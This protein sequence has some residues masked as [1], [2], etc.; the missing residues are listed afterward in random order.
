MLVKIK[1]YQAHAASELEFNEPG[2]N[3]IIGPSDSGKSSIIRAIS[4]LVDGSPVDRRHKTRETVVEVDGCRRVRG[5]SANQFE[6]G[7]H[8]YKAMRSEAPREIKEKLNLETINFRSQHQPYFLLADSPGAV[9]RSMNELADLG[10]IDYV[11]TE[12]KK[13]AR[14]ASEQV[15]KI[16]TDIEKHEAE[17]EQL[18][19]AEQAE[20]DWQ[21]ISVLRA[22][23]EGAGLKAGRLEDQVIELNDLQYRLDTI[24]AYTAADVDQLLTQI[25]AAEQATVIDAQVEGAD[26][27][28]TWL[29][30]V[31]P[32]IAADIL[33]T[34]DCLKAIVDSGPLQRLVEEATEYEEDLRLCPDTGADLAALAE[35][36]QIPF[37]PN[38]VRILAEFDAL[39][40]DADLPWGPI[41]HDLGEIT[42]FLHVAVGSGEAL[43]EIDR[44]VGQVVLLGPDIA[45]LNSELDWAKWEFDKKLQEAGV[46]PLCGGSTTCQ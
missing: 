1:N 35:A 14:A 6:I 12:L 45:N 30:S 46:C 17:I 29:L 8:V 27:A 37:N 5:A 10:M 22:E 11:Q 26:E 25:R 20:L 2:I 43:R 38:L 32:V 33:R 13:L 9:A 18:R 34:S 7:D 42:M 28:I 40:V 16:T 4:S 36:A 21:A 23:G 19:W 41:Q 39:P 44:L 15:S 31:P 24:P 3:V